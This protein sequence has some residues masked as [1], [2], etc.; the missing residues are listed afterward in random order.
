MKKAGELTVQHRGR[1]LN[2]EGS[3]A[4]SSSHLRS[5]YEAR[6]NRLAPEQLTDADRSVIERETG[7]LGQ[8]CRRQTGNGVAGVLK[9]AEERVADV[10]DGLRRPHLNLA[11]IPGG[12]LGSLEDTRNMAW[13]TRQRRFGG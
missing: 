4:S 11:L 13:L 2:P 10:C 3:Y 7:P 5:M 8:N 12:Q 1:I 9:R 6:M